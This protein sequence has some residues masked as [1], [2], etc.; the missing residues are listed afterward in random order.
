MTGGRM[1]HLVEELQAADLSLLR[2]TGEV[3]Y[4]QDPEFLRLLQGFLSRRRRLL[5]LIRARERQVTEGSC[6]SH[7]I[8][9]LR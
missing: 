2:L 5:A 7:T 6:R 3:H 1:A 9:T 4:E 8:V